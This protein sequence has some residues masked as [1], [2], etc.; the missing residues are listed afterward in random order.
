[1]QLDTLKLIDLLGCHGKNCTEEP[2]DL[3]LDLGA[4]TGSYTEK[5][6]V[7]SFAKNYIMIEANPLTQ[8]ILQKRWGSKRWKQVWFTQ[9]VTKSGRTPD[10]E[11]INQAL[12][13]NSK[14][15]LDICQTEESMLA[16]TEGECKVSIASIDD[17]VPAKLTPL[18]QEHFNQAQSA[19]IKIDTEGMSELVLRG[20]PRLLEE[21]R[22]QYEDGSP[23]HLVNFLQFEVSPWLMQLAK[24]REGFQEYD[25]KSVTQFL[26][27]AGFETFLIG[28]RYLPLSHTSWDDEFLAFT[29]DPNNNAGIRVNY[30][31]F[32]DRLCSVCN[33]HYHESFTGDI[34]AIRASHPRLGELKLALGACQESRDFDMKDPQYTFVDPDSDIYSNR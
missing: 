25:I 24:E 2:F 31:N 3:M 27:S 7:R 14:G 20:M 29:N 17:L 6:T 34:F 21:T 30:P 4:C 28:P 26:E 19:Y 15:V 18:F 13:N 8:D 9:Q 16:G 33:S 11:L 12:S 32:D 1:M 10:F 5:L 23:R 22:G